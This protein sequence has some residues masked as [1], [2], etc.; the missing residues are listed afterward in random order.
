MIDEQLW[1]EIR[2]LS[3]AGQRSQSEIAQQLGLS[4][5]TVA[6]ALT[7][8]TAP[9]YRRE[10]RGSIVSPHEE[11]IRARLREHPEISAARLLGELKLRG[12]AGGYTAL[13]ERLRELRPREIEAFVRRE[14]E[15]GQEAQVDWGSFGTMEID[16]TRRPLSC[17]V[18]V[19][20]YSRMLFVRFTLTQLL[21]QFL[22]SHLE[23][24]E[25]FGGV[26]HRALYDK[27]RSV[28]LARAGSS[29][30]FNPRFAEFAGIC[31]F[32]PRPC[33]V[34]RG[35]E[36]GKVER[37]IRY[38]R[39]SFFEGRRFRDLADLNT[40][41]DRWRD[42]VANVRLHSVTRERPKD[43]LPRD[44]THLL[45]LPPK[46]VDVDVVRPVVASSQC[47]VR[48]DG[49][50]YSV[51]VAKC[52]KPLLLRASLRLVRLFD[53]DEL[54]AEHLRSWGRH[55]VFERPEHVRT[56]L[57]RKRAARSAKNRD[58]LIA[59]C[60]EGRAY[61][62]GLLS[63]GRRLDLHLSRIA[64]LC[65]THG[66]TTVAAGIA[67]ALARGLFGAGYVE[68]LLRS[69]T[70]R[71]PVANVPLDHAPEL[72]SVRVAPHPLEVYDDASLR[73]PRSHPLD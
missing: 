17:F 15:P 16:G 20:G 63:T 41:A 48:F 33:G 72:T 27:L 54:V 38:I 4:R 32:E 59:L 35:N 45:A 12:Y 58:L 22:A 70:A 28:V 30:R 1:A 3:L 53:R 62:D 23:A 19:L 18:M 6:R 56:L 7:S 26:P 68:Q 25:F 36:K 73:R 29:I 55:R 11:A 69:R 46:P 21:E 64:D 52:R 24:F 66:R 37:A 31:M 44:R 47:L 65:D 57:D 13:K 42:E 61:L 39:G 40:Q 60:D 8:D 49:N 67:N 51:P 71:D 2:R 50:A 9:K 5:S 43:R 10:P 34:R 14:T